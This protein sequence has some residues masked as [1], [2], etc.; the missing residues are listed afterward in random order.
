MIIAVPK[1]IK[2]H[3]YRVALT[4]GAVGQL[5]QAGSTVL[6]EQSAGEGSG[7]ADKDFKAAGATILPDHARVFGE[8]D[9]V[10]KVK[11]PLKEEWP[12]LREGQVLFSYLHLAA[13]RDLTEAL[14]KKGVTAVAYE[15][16][17]MPNGFL[18][19]LRPMS[20]VAG[21]M[22][23]Q[24]GAYHLQRIHGGSGVL[25]PGVPG[26]S[27]ARVVILGA[28]TVGT[29]AARMAVGLGAQVT[30]FHQE[31][32]RLR[33]LDDIYQGRIVTRVSH[34]ELVEQSLLSADLLIGA[35]LVVGAK[36]PRLVGRKQVAAM[37]RGS[38]I[39]DVSIDQ[40]GCVETARPTTHS[41]PVY[42]EEG[43]VHYCVTNMPGAYPRTSTVALVNESL[44]YVTRIA[45]HGLEEACRTDPA[46]A[47]GINVKEGTIRHPAVARAFESVGR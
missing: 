27:P 9:M 8:A 28:G 36:T 44:P 41:D 45:A 29:N 16:I 11:E 23:A 26:V 1:E 30:I 37:R 40:G 14:M 4:P 46:L 31:T 47:G 22:A 21:R 34:P 3:E 12:L 10:V 25:L 19:V 20:E 2:D 38:V 32:E 15:T 7:Y 35:V 42:I 33:Y 13:N 18:P 5:V 17:Q 39:V 24:V 43:V 6:V